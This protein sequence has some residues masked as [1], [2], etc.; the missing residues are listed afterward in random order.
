MIDF[1]SCL[2]EVFS[3]LTRNPFLK[4][5]FL[6]GRDNLIFLKKYRSN[7]V[8]IAYSYFFQIPM[9]TQRQPQLKLCFYPT[10]LPFFDPVPGVLT[11][12]SHPIGGRGGQ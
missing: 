1:Q 12:P 8:D 3:G 7:Y 5:I 4:T 10:F 11:A 9:W 6:D 2:W